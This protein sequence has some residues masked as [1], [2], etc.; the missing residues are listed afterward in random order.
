MAQLRRKYGIGGA[1]TIRTWAKNYS[2][3]GLLPKRI[4]VEKPNEQDQIAA[5]K[6]EI[7]RLK[8]AIADEVLDRKIA[9]S[10]LEV[11]CRQQGWSMDEV[12]KK[13]GMKQPSKRSAKKKK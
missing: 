7:L 2:R 13:I 3:F 5:L 8:Q 12:K 9:E 4:R 11:I 10:H 1:C 6:A